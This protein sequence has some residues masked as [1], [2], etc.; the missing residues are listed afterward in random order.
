MGLDALAIVASILATT[1]RWSEVLTSFADVYTSAPDAHSTL[2]PCEV[3]LV[4]HIT[5]SVQEG[6]LFL[7][8]VS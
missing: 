6:T 1:G 5:R 8:E 2:P 3:G 4:R 7:A